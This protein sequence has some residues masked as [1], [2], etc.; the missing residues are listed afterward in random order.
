MRMP[1]I[2]AVT[3]ALKGARADARKY[4]EENEEAMDVRLQVYPEG[5]WAIRTGS[6]DYDLDHKGWWGAGAVSKEDT[7]E[8]LRVLAKSLIGQVEEHKASC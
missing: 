3:E 8:D 1:S 5:Y 2:T 6:S 4:L 7:V